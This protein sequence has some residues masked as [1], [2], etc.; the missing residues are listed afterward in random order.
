MLAYRPF[1]AW[2]P[3]SDWTL[4]L[5]PG[6]EALSIAVG[7]QFCAVATSERLLRVYSAA[8]GA[9]NF[10][11]TMPVLLHVGHLSLGA[12]MLHDADGTCNP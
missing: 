4:G 7:S 10:F 5:P 1:G 3:N 9:P 2:V 12:G 8:G 6:E 11:P